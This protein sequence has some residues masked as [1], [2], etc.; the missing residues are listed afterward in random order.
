MKFRTAAWAVLSAG[1]LLLVSACD[2]GPSAVAGRNRSQA[3]ETASNEAPERSRPDEGGAS[4][5]ADHRTEAA[6]KVD[7]QAM[8][9]ASKR[10]SAAEG[11]QHTFER[12]GEAFGA[13]S[14]D[15]FVRKAHDFVTNPP[16]GVETLKRPNG[17][18]LF[19]D[20]KG[21]VFAVANKDGL[22]KTM[23]K[24]DDGAAY[25]QEQKDRDA[26]R[27]TARAEHRDGGGS[28]DETS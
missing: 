13:R 7:G 2:N 22:P 28:R 17:D 18:T 16:S 27:Q 20:R 10:Y 24:P 25:W 11:A 19:Y 8:W 21:N 4:A 15:E 23:F 6:L 12:N 1:A 26:K 9:S 3:A 5:P 14:V